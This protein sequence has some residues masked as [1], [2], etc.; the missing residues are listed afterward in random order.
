M[1][2]EQDPPEDQKKKSKP[3]GEANLRGHLKAEGADEK[4]ESGSAS[5]V[6]AKKEDDKQLI[7]ALN[8]LRGVKIDSRNSTAKKETVPN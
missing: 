1:V 4:E 6:P 2:I 8:F 5:Y 7:Y 3:R